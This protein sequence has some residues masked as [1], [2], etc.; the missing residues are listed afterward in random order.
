MNEGKNNFEDRLNSFMKNSEER[1]IDIR[2][3]LKNKQGIVK[4]RR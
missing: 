1:Q 3:N 4:R 2:R